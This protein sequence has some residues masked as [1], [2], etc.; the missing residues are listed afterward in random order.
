MATL[1][2]NNQLPIDE[3]MDKADTYFFLDDYQQAMQ[4]Y[5]KAADQNHTRAMY[6]IG[7]M[8]Q[9]GQGVTKDDI[10]AKNWFQKAANLGSE[11]AKKILK[12]L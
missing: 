9:R 12:N 10:T 8:Y 4:W 5:L 2:D 7:F 6:N 11:K 1:S 3:I